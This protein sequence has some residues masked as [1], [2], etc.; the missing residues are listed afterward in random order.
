MEEDSVGAVGKHGKSK[1]SFILRPCLV[2]N[3]TGCCCFQVVGYIMNVFFNCFF[4]TFFENT[5]STALPH[6]A[7]KKSYYR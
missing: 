3:E 4:I 2:L 6:P 5:H 1:Q 7:V